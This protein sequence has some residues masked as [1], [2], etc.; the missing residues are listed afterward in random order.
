MP[1]HGSV[2][3]VADTRLR[4]LAGPLPA[5]TY[6]PVAGGGAAPLLV[7]LPG[8][9]I[10]A[11]DALCRAVCSGAGVVVLCVS[12]R[13]PVWP[14]G[15]FD[16]ILATEWAADHAGELGADPDRLLVAG[17]GTG[18]ALAAAV[19]GHAREQG[20]PPLVHL[21]LDELLNRKEAL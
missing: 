11:A 10:E 15:R 9:G 12:Y 18:A 13:Q 16:A 21:V 14:D 5:R 7:F 1:D 19:A 4:G 2:R 8:G 17:D 3:L 20:W 6:W